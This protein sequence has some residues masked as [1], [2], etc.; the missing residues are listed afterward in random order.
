MSKL[1][2]ARTSRDLLDL[3]ALMT[4]LTTAILLIILGHCPADQRNHLRQRRVRVLAS[5]R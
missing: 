2:A 1:P 5:T 3:I 4:V